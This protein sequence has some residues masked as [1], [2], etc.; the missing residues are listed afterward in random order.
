MIT[1]QWYM[2]SLYMLTGFIPYHHVMAVY[3]G[4]T[5]VIIHDLPVPRQY[6]HLLCSCCLT[7]LISTTINADITPTAPP[8]KE[9]TIGSTSLSSSY[10]KKLAKRK[11][12]QKEKEKKKDKSASDT[13]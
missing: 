2:F 5:S 9:A 1:T 8:E 4:T 7:L 3:T 10:E 6:L 13:Y 12:K 11:H